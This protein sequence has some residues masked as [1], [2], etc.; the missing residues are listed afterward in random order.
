MQD[1]IEYL[2]YLIA[3]IIITQMNLINYSGL[4]VSVY[5]TVYTAKLGAYNY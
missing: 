4:T 2:H 5:K 3:V 1:N